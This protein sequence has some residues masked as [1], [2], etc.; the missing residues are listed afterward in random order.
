[1]SLAV[2]YP[3][4]NFEEIRKEIE[5]CKFK[6]KEEESAFRSGWMEAMLSLSTHQVL[7]QVPLNTK[8]NDQ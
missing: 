7:E 5:K 1:M 8:P 2:S 4:I 3:P 6:T